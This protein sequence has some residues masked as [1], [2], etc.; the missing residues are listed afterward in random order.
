M[1]LLDTNV[2]SELRRLGKAHPAVRDWQA[3][4]Q[5]RL[6]CLSPITIAEIAYGWR[7]IAMREPERARILKSWIDRV[8]DEFSARVV[9]I[10]AATG[11]EFARLMMG[12]SRTS[13]DQWLAAS[14][15][16]HGLTIVTRNTADFADTGVRLLNPWLFEP[17]ATDPEGGPISS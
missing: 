1:Y 5:S 4:T 10:D 11:L 12:R 16:A 17:T 14:A 15:L 2:L 9:P 6:L 3:R 13:S 8:L 7:K